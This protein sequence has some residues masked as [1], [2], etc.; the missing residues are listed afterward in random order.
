MPCKTCWASAKQAVSI[1]R[2]ESWHALGPL[3]HRLF[4]DVNRD[5]FTERDGW[6]HMGVAWSHSGDDTRQRVDSDNGGVRRRPTRGK[7][8]ISG[9]RNGLSDAIAAILEANRQ[10]LTDGNRRVAR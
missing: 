2:H 7:W 9:V 1:A 10:P 8:L 6:R 5:D 4:M 3:R